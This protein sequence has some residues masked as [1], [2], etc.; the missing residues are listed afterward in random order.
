MPPA[1][2]PPTA[3]AGG[4]P[5]APNV[6]YV[7]F[8]DASIAAWDAFGGLIDMPNMKRLAGC[9]TRSGTRPPFPP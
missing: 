4:H 2:R 7:V 1:E 9:A 5:G 6:L 3:A 8:E